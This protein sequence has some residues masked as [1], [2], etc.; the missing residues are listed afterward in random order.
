MLNINKELYLNCYIKDFKF[1]NR[2]INNELLR[3]Y[4]SDRIE[5]QSLCI[6]QI[7]F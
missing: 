2:H 4:M 7:K 1:I 3:L 6:P 5:D